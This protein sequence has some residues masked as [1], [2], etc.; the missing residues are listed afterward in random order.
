MYVVG[1]FTGW[2]PNI[3]M[4][5]AGDV[6]VAQDV[7]I[8][9]GYHEMKFANTNDWSGDDWG[10]AT[11]LSGHAELA[12]GGGPNI[13]FVMPETGSYEIRFND[14]SLAYQIGEG[15]TGVGDSGSGLGFGEGDRSGQLRL[16]PN[17]PNPFG[18]ETA[19][20]FELAAAADVRVEVYDVGGR[21]AAVLSEG[22]LGPGEH[23]VT[24][25]GKDDS[26]RD[27]AAGVYFV[28]VRSEGAE[29][30]RKMVRV[31]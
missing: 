6:W 9:A 25:D 29:L 24:W 11:G 4:T 26:G 23:S 15:G 10:N 8:T 18:L 21:L 28:S 22:F 5:L 20:E 27:V 12:T 16:R 14:F 17:D 7:E 2:S 1:T 19:I 30:R 3:P 31:R 13:S